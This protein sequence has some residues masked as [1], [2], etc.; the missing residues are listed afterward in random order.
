LLSERLWKRVNQVRQ[1]LVEIGIDAPAGHSAILPLI[2]G[3][4]ED[5]LNAALKL[6]KR[7]VYI[8]AIRYPAVARNRARLRLTL[9]A[10]HSF[11]DI[12]QLLAALACLQ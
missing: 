6:R 10:A 4:E 11:A 3:R 1:G 12:R 7:G 2:I 5:A 9:S 8:P